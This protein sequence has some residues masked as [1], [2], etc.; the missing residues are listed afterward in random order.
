M[1]NQTTTPPPADDGIPVVTIPGSLRKRYGNYFLIGGILLAEFLLAYTI[2][3][4]NYPQIYQW[5]YGNP[6]DFGGYYEIR[7]LVVNPA[8][9]EGTRYLLLSVGLEVRSSRDMDRI[10]QREVVIRDA[11]IT[12]MG[13]RTVS[14]LASIEERN[15]IKQEMGIMINQI[16]GQRAVRNLFF[17]QY[18]MQ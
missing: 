12:M 9:T 17:T 6:P 15:A 2:V 11:I 16:L 4:L 10:Q 18:V 13:R 8:G 5:V 3:A 14:E 1:A 7:E